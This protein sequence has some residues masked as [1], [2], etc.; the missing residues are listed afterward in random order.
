L[1]L[2]DACLRSCGPTQGLSSLVQD[3]RTEDVRDGRLSMTGMAYA[4]P[5]SLNWAV[6]DLPTG[7][8]LH[9]NGSPQVLG[10]TSADWRTPR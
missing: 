5:G 9:F 6:I 10:V 3:L 4:R 8:A 7:S 2:S 1:P